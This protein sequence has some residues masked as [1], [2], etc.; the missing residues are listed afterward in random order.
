MCPYYNNN[1]C[2]SDF[3]LKIP[4]YTCN[5]VVSEILCHPCISTNSDLLTTQLILCIPINTSIRTNKG[6]LNVKKLAADS[7]SDHV[8]YVHTYIYILHSERKKNKRSGKK[9]HVQ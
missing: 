4:Y 9:N 6:K 8:L 3:S 5:I 1:K 2:V 7:K